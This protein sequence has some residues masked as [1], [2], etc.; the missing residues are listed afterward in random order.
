MNREKIL[1]A[2][3]YTEPSEFGEFCKALGD[4]MPQG[5]HE[6]RD[7]FIELTNCEREGLVTVERSGGKIEQMQ[8]TESGSAF[9]KDKADARRPMFQ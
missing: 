7:L 8:L 3:G 9:V 1:L 4:D 6:W 5:S 2:I